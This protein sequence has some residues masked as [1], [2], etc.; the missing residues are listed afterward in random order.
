MDHSVCS[1][2]K[3]HIHFVLVLCPKS[4]KIVAYNLQLSGEGHQITICVFHDNML[5]EHL[6][7]SYQLPL[8]P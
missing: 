3:A 7:G 4:D 2:C 1:T 8:V 5:R 6:Y